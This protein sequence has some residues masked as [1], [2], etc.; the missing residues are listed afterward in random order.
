MAVRQIADDRSLELILIEEVLGRSGAHWVVQGSG[1][2]I[3]LAAQEPAHG[4]AERMWVG[5]V[6]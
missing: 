4:D 5:Q 1:G 3:Y 2:R 6:V